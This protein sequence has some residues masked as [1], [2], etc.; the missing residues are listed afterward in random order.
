VFSGSLDVTCSAPVI[1]DGKTI[2]VVGIDIVIDNIDELVEESNS[3]AKFI[4]VVNSD[5]QIIAVPKNN[6]IFKLEGSDTAQDLRKSDNAELAGFVTKA[7]EGNT[8]LEIVTLNGKEYY[9]TSAKMDTIGWAVVSVVDKEMTEGSTKTLLSEITRINS[10]SA[11]T[12]RSATGLQSKITYGV[13]IFIVLFGSISAII[14]ANKIVRPIESMTED[15]GIGAKTGKLFEMKE[16]YRTGDEIQVL[17]EAFDDLSKKTK[18][19][20]ENLTEITKEKERIGT[21]LSLATQIQASMLPHIFPPFPDR[22]EFDIYASMDPARE[23]GGD[24]YDFFLIDDDHLCMVMADVSGKGIPAALFMMI[25]KTILQSCAMLGVSV[26]EILAKTNEAL[27]TNNQ[28][29]MFVTVWLGVLEISTGRLTAA[30]AG[31]EYPAIKRADGSFELFKDKHGFVIGGMEGSR[32]KEYTIDLRKGDKLFLYTD[33]VP[34]AT[35]AEEDMFGTDR[36]LEALNKEANASPEQILKNV[37]DSVSDFVK[38]AEQFDDMT[39]MCIE[40]K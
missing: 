34:E 25:S 21:E 26:A 31:H 33:G 2:A 14:L 36:M 30:N 23:V 27:C 32:Y 29:D 6:S 37:K 9:L 10:S 17:A 4:F 24:F 38:D 13:I 11:K 35:N 15:I 1:V 3:Q 12:F 20:I 22:N 16:V 5:G 8:G 18:E 40:I 7:L 28:V 39:M 19:Y